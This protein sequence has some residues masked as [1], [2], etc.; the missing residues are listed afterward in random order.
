MSK[1]IKRF[2]K[3]LKH[4]DQLKFTAYHQEENLTGSLK[5]FYDGVESIL[6]DIYK[7]GVWEDI[8]RK[9]A[10]YRV[11]EIDQILNLFY[12]GRRGVS[13]TPDIGQIKKGKTMIFQY[14]NRD[15][16]DFTITF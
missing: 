16:M 9:V 2:S 15:E 11:K 1:K 6:K 8:K 14:V 3:K 10:R 5:E 7:D 12:S 13:F 4:L